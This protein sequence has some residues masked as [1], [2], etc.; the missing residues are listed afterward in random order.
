MSVDSII[1]SIAAKGKANLRV[2]VIGAGQSAAEVTLNLR[3]RLRSIPAPAGRHQI[4]MIIRK[5][6]LRPSDDTPFANEIFDPQGMSSSYDGMLLLIV[7]SP[8]TDAWF[9]HPSSASRATQLQEFKST[10][11]SVIN[12]LTLDAVRTSEFKIATAF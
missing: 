11:Y 2:A 5:G 7:L 4:D 8:A 6:A 1:D 12:S 10:N 3:E 9:S